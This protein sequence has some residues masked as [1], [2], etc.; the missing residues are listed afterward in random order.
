MTLSE[1]SNTFI[2]RI[3]WV[4][5]LSGD[6]YTEP[7]LASGGSKD[8]IQ[9]VFN[10]YRE[11]VRPD[12]F[13]HE[14]LSPT[15]RRSASNPRFTRETFARFIAHVKSR[16]HLLDSDWQDVVKAIQG[17]VALHG[18]KCGMI[19]H[20]HDL[21]TQIDL[22]GLRDRDRNEEFYRNTGRAPL[23]RNWTDVPRLVCMVLI[24]PRAKL[25]PIRNDHSELVPR[26]VCEYGSV[27]NLYLTHSSIQTVWG[28][29]VPLQDSD[30]KYVIEEDPEGLYGSS[31]LVVSFWTDAEMLVP[32]D[33]NVSLCLRNTPLMSAEYGAELGPRL[34]LY[35]TDVTDAEHVLVLR[36]R[37]MGA[38]QTQVA[39]RYTP[40]SITKGLEGVE[41]GIKVK[42]EGAKDDIDSMI[43]RFRVNKAK[44]ANVGVGSV[45]QVGPCT[46][47]VGFG[48]KKR[49]I[50][51][52]YPVRGTDC[53]VTIDKVGG[54]IEV[55]AEFFDPISTGGYPNTP[56]PILRRTSPSPWN[57]HHLHLERMPKV[58]T[59]QQTQLHKWLV[60]HTSVQMSDRERVVQRSSHV[61]QRPT[62]ESLVGV[63]ESIA[64]LVQDYVGIRIASQGPLNTFGLI[65]PRHGFYIM[66]FV[67]GLKLDLGNATLA[68]DCAVVPISLESGEELSPGIA[69]LDAS[70]P[71]L[72]VRTRPAE[73]IA[74]KHLLPAFVERC[75][76]WSHKP[77]CAYK[78]TGK[79]PLSEKIEVDPLCKCGRGQ[80]LSGPEWKNPAWKG[81][82]PYA[83]RAA[84]SP[85]FGVPILE[86]VAGPASTMTDTKKPVSW[87]KPTDVCWR[88]GGVGRPLLRCARCK[89][90][91]YCSKECQKTHW[92]EEHK[93]VCKAP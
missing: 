85:L 4:S 83:T 51:F 93:N 37:P 78:K 48:G 55:V 43:A 82:L 77:D 28:K 39:R 73:V 9:L 2:E 72:Q 19:N 30:R 57:V 15:E 27:S 50:R 66:I 62:S 18:T 58:D 92:N 7:T 47:N 12:S 20:F 87:G 46:L 36:E 54:T 45:K 5:P 38:G 23:F 49:T 34:Q 86:T 6:T 74:W 14:D 26:L 80:N 68:L 53:R 3:P 25:D 64:A 31:D 84:I 61:S 76:M 69:L 81:L 79:I 16:I 42:Q 67:S 29:C 41:Y 13:S 32:T 10:V 75:R 65:E 59:R 24:V 21:Y 17:L 63:K 71:V 11:M 52:P 88:C 56:F 35:T 44:L 60:E 1:S 22:Y 8:I 70:T 40:T 91:R 33:T 89:K 90:A